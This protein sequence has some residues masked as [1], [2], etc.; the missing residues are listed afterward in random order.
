ME[1]HMGTIRLV[2]ERS[3]G[4]TM[5]ERVA[6]ALRISIINQWL[7][8]GEHLVESK[9]A[10]EI[11]V[12]ATPVRHALMQLEKEGLV[13]AFP[14]RGTFVKTLTRQFVKEVSTLRRVLEIEAARQ[15]FENITSDN[16]HCMQEYLNVMSRP[17]DQTITMYDIS[18]MD[19]LFHNLIFCSS[20]NKLLME[21]WNLVCPRVQLISSYNKTSVSG[22]VQKARHVLLIEDI[23]KGDKEKFLVDL[24]KH[25]NLLEHEYTD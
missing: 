6:D 5:A 13:D 23:V 2:F 18:L 12:S 21:M 17:I 8:A 7:K 20:K 14:Y 22:D 10:E 16:I 15:A 19:V 24:E 11:N 9:V 3:T 1:I 25:C 4:K